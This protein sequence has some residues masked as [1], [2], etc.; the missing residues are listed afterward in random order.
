MNKHMNKAKRKIKSKSKETSMG[1][2]LLGKRYRGTN[3][4]NGFTCK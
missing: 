4:W 3:R 1:M 2:G